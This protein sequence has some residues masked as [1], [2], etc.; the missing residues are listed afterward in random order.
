MSCLTQIGNKNLGDGKRKSVFYHS[1]WNVCSCVH[2]CCVFIQLCHTQEGILSL[3]PKEDVQTHWRPEQAW[4]TLNGGST[5]W[6]WAGSWEEGTSWPL[7]GEKLKEPH[8]PCLQLRHGVSQRPLC[9]GSIPGNLLPVGRDHKPDPRSPN[10]S[11]FLLTL[12]STGRAPHLASRLC[13]VQKGTY[14]E[15]RPKVSF[16]SC[17]ETN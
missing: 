5:G 7:T 12:R 10:H 8:C 11:W 1:S 3:S 2:S 14:M 15:S 4:K 13:C 6:C 9:P 16:S 17:S